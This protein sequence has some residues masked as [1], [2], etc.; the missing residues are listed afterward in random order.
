M[1]I[2]AVFCLLV[3]AACASNGNYG[4]SYGT[5]DNVGSV[6]AGEQHTGYGHTYAPEFFTTS[7]YGPRADA[8]AHGSG[9][10][11][12][13]GSYARDGQAAG[14]DYEKDEATAA[15]TAARARGYEYGYRD[16]YS[17]YQ[18]KTLYAFQY[19][20][21]ILGY[22]QV[23]GHRVIRQGGYGGYGS[24]AGYGSGN[25]NLGYGG[26]G[27]LQVHSASSPVTHGPRYNTGDSTNLGYGSNIGYGSNR[28]YGR[29]LGYGNNLGYSRNI[30]YGSNV[31]YGR[32]LGSGSNIGYGNNLGYGRNL[33][34][35][36]NLG[37]GRNLGYGNSI[38][39]GRNLGYGSNV[40][41]GRNLGYG[42]NLEYGNADRMH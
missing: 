22:R 6:D 1:K 7:V 42:G 33:G 21:P 34:Y 36:N 25:N 35:G 17:W 32:N 9:S 38:G 2:V 18:P 29:N 28:G 41:Y 26:N 20:Q 30:G 24:G 14:A 3:A 10:K 19:K 16:G 13:S 4:G 11:H 12:A 31:G 8:R 27:G 37:Y 23:Y 15:E 5:Y 39:Y 40:G